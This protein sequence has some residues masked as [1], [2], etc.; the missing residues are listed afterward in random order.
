MMTIKEEKV[1]AETTLS[2]KDRL[3]S[4]A[5]NLSDF[6]AKVEWTLPLQVVEVDGP[7]KVVDGVAVASLDGKETEKKTVPIVRMVIFILLHIFMHAST[8]AWSNSHKLRR[9]VANYKF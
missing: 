5:S 3:N 8:R 7:T 9:T 4:E 6:K 1:V 2:N